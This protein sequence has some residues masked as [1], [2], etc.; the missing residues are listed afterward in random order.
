MKTRHRKAVRFT[1]TVYRL[2]SE[3]LEDRLVLASFAPGF[4]ADGAVGSLREAVAIANANG[5]EDEIQLQAGVYVLTMMEAVD[6]SGGD[7]DFS[8]PGQQTRIVGAGSGNTVIDARSLGHQAIH[9]LKEAV[10]ELEGVTVLAGEIE[11]NGAG[12]RNDGT[13]VLR[14]VQ[15]ALGKASD[16]CSLQFWHCRTRERVADRETVQI[17]AEV[18]PMRRAGV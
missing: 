14:D 5:E 15:I 7:L 6:G 17:V 3:R 12:I 9:V 13:L 4:V 2:Q 11:D 8:D 10:V 18:S 1:G 16:G